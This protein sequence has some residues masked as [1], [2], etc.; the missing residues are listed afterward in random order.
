MTRFRVALLVLLSLLSACGVSGLNFVAD[1]RVE[2]IA[3]DDREAVRLPLTVAWDV[4]RFEVTGRDGEVS[5]GAG[6]F[7]VYVDRA[8]QPPG[9]TQE[10]LVR[11]D[12]KCQPPCPDESYLAGLNVF[13]TNETTFEIERLPVPSGNAAKRRNFHEVTIVLLNGR[14][15]RIGESAF[16]VQFEVG[17]GRTG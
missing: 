10:W 3:P 7:G 14:G 1:E 2:I 5:S 4:E 17:T 16:T 8:P 6:Y 13:S 11:N 9:L 15:E 12:P